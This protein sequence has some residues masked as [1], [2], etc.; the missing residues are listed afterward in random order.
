MTSPASDRRLDYI[1]ET[2]DPPANKDLW[3][4]GAS[5][6]GSLRGVSAEAAAWKPAPDRHSI[7]ELALHVAYW[8]YAVRRLLLD[9][10]KGGFPRSPS[11]WPDV[12]E[13]ADA[14]AWKE[15]LAL[16]RAEEKRLLEAVRA[17]D[18]DRLDETPPGND[19]RTVADLL[20]GIVMHDTYHTGQI[21]IMKRLYRALVVEGASSGETGT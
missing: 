14:D 5:P 7:W 16:C 13:P 4:G 10:E 11:N 9:E 6:L 18:P 20:M 2:L 12:P 15:D 17:V 19:N 3:F 8:R 21:Q 1:L